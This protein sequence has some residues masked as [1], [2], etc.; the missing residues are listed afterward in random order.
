MDTL[1]LL[2]YDGP[3]AYEMANPDGL[4][5]HIQVLQV[6]PGSTRDYSDSSDEES[7]MIKASEPPTTGASGAKSVGRWRRGILPSD[8]REGSTE[9]TSPKT[10]FKIFH[11]NPHMY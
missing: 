6:G 4:T 3:Q 7:A 2:A 11:W 1:S 10:K 5:S 9:F 8:V